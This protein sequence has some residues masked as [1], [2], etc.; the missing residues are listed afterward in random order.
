MIVARLG[1]LS[2]AS[3]PLIRLGPWLMSSSATLVALTYLNLGGHPYSCP[4]YAENTRL[5]TRLELKPISGAHPFFLGLDLH[6]VHN[7]HPR[8]PRCP[9]IPSTLRLHIFCSH[10]NLVNQSPVHYQQ[11]SI[12]ATAK[13]RLWMPLALAFYTAVA[14]AQNS[15]NNIINI[16]ANGLN[17]VAGQAITI[18]WSD[19]SSS[20]VTIKLQQ[21]DI[22]PTSGFVLAC[23]WKDHPSPSATKNLPH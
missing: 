19:P 6:P 14:F 21:T 22:T 3:N 7:S 10:Y 15:T 13:M 8:S 23:T 9:Y 16:P 4:P 18:T 5:P 20:T 11:Q 1:K 17:V 2:S 12:S